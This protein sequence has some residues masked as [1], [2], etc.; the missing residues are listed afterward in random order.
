MP[1]PATISAISFV[2]YPTMNPTNRE[3][4]RLFAASR[5]YPIAAAD[6]TAPLSGGMTLFLMQHRRLR[7]AEIRPDFVARSPC[8]ARSRAGG[9]QKILRP[10]GRWAP[11][12]VAAWNNPMSDEAQERESSESPMLNAFC[13]VAPSVLFSFLAILDAG[14]FLFAMVFKSR[15]SPEVHARRFFVLLAIEPPFQMR[16]VVSLAGAEEKPKDGLNNML[17]PTNDP[18]IWPQMRSC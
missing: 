18:V 4:S 8:A 12:G 9:K 13:R 1:N 6:E 16:R 5:K 17:L 11:A 2:L 14:V 7:V 3:P 10:A 15:T